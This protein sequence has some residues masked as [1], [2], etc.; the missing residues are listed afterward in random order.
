[1]GRGKIVKGRRQSGLI[2]MNPRIVV[3]VG[4]SHSIQMATGGT[5]QQLV[6][7]FEAF[8]TNLCAT[9]G[10]RGVAEELNPEALALR[11]RSTSIPQRIAVARKLEHRFCDPN[12]QER[13]DLGIVEETQI[14]MKAW[15]HEWSKN[16]T[17]TQ[18]TM[19]RT[20]RE[21][22]WLR[23]LNRME[24]WPVLFVCGANHMSSF[25]QIL[26]QDNITVCVA[27]KDW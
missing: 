18:Q 3:L 6:D 25:Q 27:A 1:M 9:K 26:E 14:E 17:A 10:I 4:T 19:H 22:L 16:E 13:A 24:Q 15:V 12:R 20:M 21:R 7:R 23:E 2:R 11:N 5:C 8:L